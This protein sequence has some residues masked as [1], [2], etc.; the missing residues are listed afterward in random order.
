LGTLHQANIQR[1]AEEQKS[2]PDG[3]VHGW[4][5]YH[6]NYYTSTLQSAAAHY[7]FEFDLSVPVKD[8]TQTQR[9]LLFFGVDS[10]LF[11][12]HFPTI[13]APPTVRQG[14]F[15]GIA[16]NLLR[17]YAEHIQDAEYRAKVEEFLIT[18]TCPDCGGTRL[19]PESQAITING[20]TIIDYRAWRSAISAPGWT[21]SQTSSAL[22]K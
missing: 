13:E 7:G 14:R 21:G 16:T 6:I 20:Q 2:I 12:R 5:L 15:E 19:R 10:P 8:F 22:M 9:D 18:Q 11:H 17:R 1:L 3:A 4:D